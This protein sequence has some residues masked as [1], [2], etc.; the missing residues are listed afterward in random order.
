MIRYWRT[1]CVDFEEKTADGGKPRA[2]RLVKLRFARMMLY[3]GGVAAIAPTGNASA[4][5]KRAMLLET[6]S[7]PPAVRLTETFGEKEMAKPLA[8]YATFLHAIDDEGIRKALERDG[9]EG[10]DT[11]E[12]RE[13]VEVAR[14][15]R[16]GLEGILVGPNGLRS[17]IG[18]ALL[19]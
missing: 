19:L 8:A 12:Y 6:F 17:Q 11:D 3:F 7:K 9:H 1:I 15:F 5:V 4:D 2:I 18:S 13:L 14:D 16:N 10:L